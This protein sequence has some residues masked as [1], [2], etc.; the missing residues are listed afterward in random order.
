MSGRIHVLEADFPREKHVHFAFTLE[1]G[2]ELRF[3]DARKF[4]RVY[5]LNDLDEVTGHLGP[6][7][8]EDTFTLKVLRGLMAKKSGGLKA[9]LLDQSFIAGIGTFTPMNPYGG[10]RFIHYVG[11]TLY[12]MRKLPLSGVQSGLPSR[13][14]SHMAEQLLIGSTLKANIKTTSASMVKPI[15]PAA[16]AKHRLNAFSSGSA[17]HIS[18][19]AA[20]LKLSSI[21]SDIKEMPGHYS[22]EKNRFEKSLPLS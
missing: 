8:L 11:Q 2:Y 15:S 3:D 9:L 10:P 7:P 12:R 14:A 13:M 6:E 1:N 20:S 18:V 16:A 19:Q 5:L 17:V 21:R 4:G 22:N